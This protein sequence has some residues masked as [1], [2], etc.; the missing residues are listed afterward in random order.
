M[1]YDDLPILDYGD[2]G[3]VTVAANAEGVANLAVQAFATALIT[4]HANRG[5]ATIAL[6]G[7]ST[8]KRMGELLAHSDFPSPEAWETADIFWG[9]ERWVPLDS[10]ESNAGVALRTFLT[11]VPIPA[12]NVHPLYDPELDEAQAAAV[13]QAIIEEIVDPIDGVPAF[14]LIFLGMGDD[15]H[16]ASLFPFSPGL[17]IQDRHVAPNYVEKLDTTRITFTT[18]LINGAREVVFLVTGSGK[19]ER[20]KEILEGPLEPDRLPSQLIRPTHGTLRWLV[21]QGAASQLSGGPFRE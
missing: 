2:R 12:E 14:D 8:P 15:G 21:D 1:S 16:T 10:D 18:T 7:G 17:S 20:L 19:A 13:Y 9:D 5:K 3:V 11:R 6:S 4:S